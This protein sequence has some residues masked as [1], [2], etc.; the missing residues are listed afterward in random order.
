M[1]EC[2]AQR[3]RATRRRAAGRSRSVKLPRIED[4]AQGVA[5]HV[6]GQDGHDDREAGEE[7]DPPFAG[8]ECRRRRGRSSP[9]S[10]V[11]GCA[12][13]PRYESPASSAMTLPTASVAV[14]MTGAIDVRQEVAPEDANVARAERARR[15]DVV[16]LLG[17]QR[18][19]AHEARHAEPSGGAEQDDQPGRAARDC[20]SVSTAMRRRTRGMERKPSSM[21]II[22]VSMRPPT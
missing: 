11:G 1:I 3:T 7:H 10:R 14:T 5:E 2:V 8:E 15:G 12:P 22:D 4:V 6:E 17:R 16:E 20:H 9:S 19:G 21:R 18:F 13:T